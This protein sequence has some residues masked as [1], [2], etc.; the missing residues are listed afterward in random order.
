MIWLVRVYL[1]LM[2]FVYVLIGGWAIL[3]PLASALD[4]GW[5]SF[6]D[7]IGLSVKSEIGYSE[8]AGIYGGLNLCIGICTPPVGSVIFLGCGIGKTSID[9]LIKPLIPLYLAMIAILFLITYFPQLSLFL[10]TY[11]GY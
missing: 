4:L 8:I 9:Q 3:D 11:L 7:A 5:P 1:F 10:P 2:S 6:M